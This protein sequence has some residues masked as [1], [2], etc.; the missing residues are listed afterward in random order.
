[1]VPGL[2]SLGMASS[3]QAGLFEKVLDVYEM[4]SAMLDGV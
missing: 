4:S 1:M 2:R 3:V